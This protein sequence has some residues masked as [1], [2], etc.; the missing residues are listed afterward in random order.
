NPDSITI[1][2][3]ATDH[4]VTLATTG[5]ITELGSDAAVDLTYGLLAMRAGTGIGVG[6]SIETSGV[7]GIGFGYVE[8]Q[9]DT[10]GISFSDTSLIVIGGVTST[11]TGLKVNTSGTINV[12][13]PYIDLSDTDGTEIVRGGS[14]SGDIILRLTGDLTVDVN[15]R[16]IIAPAGF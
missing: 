3:L 12:S 5:A 16:A 8:A 11:L 9:T 7:H 10:G 14:V 15:N 2:N 13:A 6:N 4:T 1:G